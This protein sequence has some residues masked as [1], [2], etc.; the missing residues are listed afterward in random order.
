MKRY[1]AV[2]LAPVV[3]MALAACSSTSN[4]GF[5]GKKADEMIDP[6]IFPADYKN[7]IIGALPQV[8]DQLNGFKDSRAT[9]PA[10]TPA[11]S[12]QVYFVCVRGN[13]RSSE[14]GY[15]GERTYIAYFMGG[16]INQL[17]PGTN[18]EHC[19]KAAYKPF[20]ELDRLCRGA[21]CTGRR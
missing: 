9:D 14:T 19:T 21:A 18:D 13:P 7:E 20:P 17:I 2:I 8:V 5:G 3:V 16:K 15:V 1:V 6:S 12:T 11:G 4:F 10:L